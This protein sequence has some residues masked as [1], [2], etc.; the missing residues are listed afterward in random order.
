MIAALTHLSGFLLPALPI[1]IANAG[2]S[3]V[4]GSSLKTGSV[5]QREG[6]NGVE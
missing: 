4:P 1:E 2:Q 3:V 5:F 6:G